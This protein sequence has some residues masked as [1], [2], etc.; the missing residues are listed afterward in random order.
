MTLEDSFR[1]LRG[2]WFD[3]HV[4]N[5]G[6]G[7]QWESVKQEDMRKAD[8]ASLRI[9]YDVDTEAIIRGEPCPIVPRCANDLCD[10]EDN[11]TD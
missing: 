8:N 5:W 3:L 1:E 7:R 4:S 9:K 2:A 6:P 10:G 11:A